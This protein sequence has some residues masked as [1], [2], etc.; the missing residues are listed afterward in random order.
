MLQQPE[1]W[2]AACLGLAG[3]KKKK[4]FPYKK[5]IVVL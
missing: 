3:N 5:K 2:C 1:L 4:K